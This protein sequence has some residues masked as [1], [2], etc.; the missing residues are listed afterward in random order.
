M[1]EPIVT[2]GVVLL[3]IAEIFKFVNRIRTSSCMGPF[4]CIQSSVT[5]ADATSQGP[6]PHITINHTTEDKKT[7]YSFG[8]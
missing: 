7:E 5:F 4:G 6:S 2:G 8:H 3:I 1:V